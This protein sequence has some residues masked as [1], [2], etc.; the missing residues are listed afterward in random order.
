M[1]NKRINLK[2]LVILLLLIAVKANSQEGDKLVLS[3]PGDVL[4]QIFIDEKPLSNEHLTIAY[5]DY[6]FEHFEVE[7][8]IKEN[9]TLE[10]L[11]QNILPQNI[12]IFY[13]Q[14]EKL[15]EANFIA[16]PNDT[17][18]LYLDP[19]EDVKIFSDNN[20]DINKLIDKYEKF[21]A[22][23]LPDAA[24]YNTALK[25]EPAAY[26][27]FHK[28]LLDQKNRI[29][30]DFCKTDSCTDVFTKWLT[31]SNQLDYNLELMKY[32]WQSF[33][34]GLGNSPQQRENLPGDYLNFVDSITIEIEEIYPYNYFSYLNSLRNKK[35]Q[36]Q[37]LHHQW[38][39]R[40]R[41]MIFKYQQDLT[42]DLQ[43]PLALSVEDAHFIR[44]VPYG[45]FNHHMWDSDTRTKYLTIRRKYESEL[46]PALNKAQ[47]QQVLNKLMKIKDP[48]EREILIY[49]YLKE[50]LFSKSDYT[51]NEVIPAAEKYLTN[52]QY[53]EDLK[54]RFN[55]FKN[56]SIDEKL[57][58]TLLK[59]NHEDTESFF[60]D[61]FARF[62]DKPILLTIWG[63]WCKPCK[64]DFQFIASKK[65]ELEDINLV[66][67]CA[68]CP[69][70]AWKKDIIKYKVDGT[71]FL[72]N[73][74]LHDDIKKTFTLNSYPSYYLVT[75]DGFKKINSRPKIADFIKEIADRNKK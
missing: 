13:L 73:S 31:T 47:F 40:E 20:S 32:T 11:V 23:R 65:E 16:Y 43:D 22:A 28:Q 2:Y 34:Y 45:R 63:T 5:T 14:P 55:S 19:Q 74:V 21:A 64:E 50:E 8:P 62:P 30:A 61:L 17:I 69:Q 36:V 54:A 18:S 67:L 66:Y 39:V 33:T 35:L 75:P 26:K 10:Y 52:V 1:I 6:F 27:A 59:L 42:S 60:K 37:E 12:R 57:N 38:F 44:N 71:H 7:V 53:Q 24:Q 68:S 48:L 56:I 58:A 15:I 3:E 9:D 49:Y 51:I 70:E 41:D 4:L 29:T 25:L 72:L 46:L